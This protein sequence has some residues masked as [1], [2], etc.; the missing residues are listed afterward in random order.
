MKLVQTYVSKYFRYV[1]LYRNSKIVSA[2]KRTTS[3]T[4]HELRLFT[5]RVPLKQFK[6]FYIRKQNE[7]KIKPIR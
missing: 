1:L 6:K 7:I 5:G 4:T 2:N 3:F